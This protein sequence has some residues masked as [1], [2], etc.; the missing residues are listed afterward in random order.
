MSY[1][2]DCPQVLILARDVSHRDYINILCKNNKAKSNQLNFVSHEFRT[3]LGCIITMLEAC[4]DDEV[5]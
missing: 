2:N 3:P 5:A 1:L 4:E